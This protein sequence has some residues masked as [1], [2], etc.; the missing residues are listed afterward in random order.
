MPQL[1]LQSACIILLNQGNPPLLP[2]D[3]K[4]TL[5]PTD[6]SVILMITLLI[7]IM[8]SL[9]VNFIGETLTLLIG[10]LL[11]IVPALIFVFVRRISFTKTFRIQPV[12]WKTLAVTVILF[13][14]VFILSDELDRIIQHF[15]PMPEEWYQSMINLVRFTSW[16]QAVAVLLAGVVF[17]AFC[18]E[19]LFRGLVQRTLE[20][21]REP[22]SA[23]VSSSV[24]FALVHFNP[25]SSIQILL[26]GLVLGY[27][28]WKSGSVFP[29]MIIH[30]LNNL[31]SL[32]MLNSPENCMRW[33]AG[34][35]HVRVI[36]LVVAAAAF[37]PAWKL[38][39]ASCRH[40]VKT[41]P[42]KE[43]I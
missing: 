24:L 22:A 21:F 16:Q 17:A 18:E 6:V 29:S 4:P 32:L 8:F 43:M 36:W 5:S 7:F 20:I 14:P 25:W 23:I 26:L 30:G 35:E 10:E 11:L 15:F 3:S 37:L 31:I 13:M 19:L 28:A 33:Y 41:A 39:T 42:S 38:F 1:L 9:L 34:E 12:Q 27:V 2:N 40:S